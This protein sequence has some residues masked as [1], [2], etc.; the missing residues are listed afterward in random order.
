MSRLGKREG[1]K[2]EEIARIEEKE[3]KR[4]WI[5]YDKIRIDESWWR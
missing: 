4:V 3:G 2:L 1:W 5:G